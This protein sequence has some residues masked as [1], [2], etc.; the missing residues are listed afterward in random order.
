MVLG[1]GHNGLKNLFS[2]TRKPF[3]TPLGKL[4][5]D[6]EF[7]E[8]LTSRYPHDLFTDEFA[9]RTE[10]T[11]EFQVLFLQLL[12]GNNI[13][14]VPILCSFAHW[15]VTQGGRPPP[16]G[17]KGKLSLLT[18][19]AALCVLTEI[20]ERGPLEMIAGYVMLDLVAELR[21]AAGL[22]VVLVSHQPEDA[23][24]IAERAAFLHDGRVLAEGPVPAL[25]DN[26]PVPELAAYLG[27][28]GSTPPRSAPR[29][30]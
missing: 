7:V 1:T 2:L 22:T 24:R 13:P 30:K 10:H 23:R 11:I 3:S 15:M 28:D 5:V 25:L 8:R 29:P 27:L 26:P 9:H 6:S 18:M 21:A 12:L 4:Q 14:M 17:R 16:I 20:D 19:L